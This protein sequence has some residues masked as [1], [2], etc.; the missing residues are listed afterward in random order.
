MIR[1]DAVS[2]W[3]I[4]RVFR[5]QTLGLEHLPGRLIAANRFSRW[6]W[7]LWV[8][9]LNE[10]SW[11]I[12]PA[13]DIPFKL[14]RSW[15]HWIHFVAEERVDPLLLAQ[16]INHGHTVVYSPEPLSPTSGWL[17][18]IT[19]SYDVS[20]PRGVMAVEGSERWPFSPNTTY[21]KRCWLP[22]I[23]LT[24]VTLDAQVDQGAR[25]LQEGL[26]RAKL[27]SLSLGTT[28]WQ[29]LITA[30]HRHGRG[31]VILEDEQGQR[32]GYGGLFFKVILL[33]GLL[34][35]RIGLETRVGVMLPTTVGAVLTF[36]ALQVCG[37]TPV[38]LNFSLGPN[39]I[40]A[41]CRI[42]RIRVVV[43][44]RQF[45]Q[46]ANLSSV[47]DAMTGLDI[48][49]LEDVRPAVT[50][51]KL[52]HAWF[53]SHFPRGVADKMQE[54]A[55]VLFT[56]GS[57]G[58][59]KGVVLSHT[60]LLANV[61]Q[62]VSRF[63]LGARDTLLS[64]LPMFH[65]FG[66]T[67]G[68]LAPLLAGMRVYCHPAVLDYRAVPRLAWKVGATVL[69]GTDTFLRG[70]GRMAQPSDFLSIRYCFAGA[71]P[72]RAATSTL[73]MEKFGIRIL[74]GYGATETAPVLAVN[75]PEGHCAGSVGRLLPG[76][77]WRLRSIPGVVE[78]GG[79]MV[80]GPNIMMG[81]VREDNPGVVQPPQAEE[82]VGWYDTGDVVRVDAAGFVWI[83]G[84]SKRFAKIGGEMISL[85]QV[86]VVAAD[87]WPDG[88]HGVV[89]IA[90]PKRGE[91]LVM[92]TDDRTMTR[93]SFTQALKN[94]GLSSLLLPSRFIYCDGLPVLASGKLDWVK[95]AQLVI[96][97]GG[98]TR[99]SA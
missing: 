76:V 61:T 35:S 51:W 31:R 48:L 12:L 13:G 15:C 88:L 6:D 37:R 71:E 16:A 21:S 69:A 68:T 70:Y 1:R 38:M 77:R 98:E 10:G 5:V 99:E 60:N 11:I 32:L 86:E 74:E 46:K 81:Y 63:D 66:L 33:S 39:T 93:Q 64:V 30:A 72:L 8:P 23:D 78:G 92:V 7:L 25:Y 79:L 14:I 54:A 57:E 95:L 50:P 53:F 85:A 47:I 22:K 87:A 42:A 27:A 29:A 97:E 3:L 90:D 96:E 28:V 91:I 43:T 20:C 19:L 45:V 44:S 24:V 40:V 9:F 58:T 4:R 82:G 49:Y 18:N 55:V 84:R 59:P 73:W 75:G 65:A 41:T 26:G 2:R 36:F 34:K 17:R 56:S 67:V 94:R 89:A 80:S 62:I 52:L 83:L